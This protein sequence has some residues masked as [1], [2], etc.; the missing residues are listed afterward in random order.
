MVAV[1]QFECQHLYL[2]GRLSV[3]IKMNEHLMTGVVSFNVTFMFIFHPNIPHLTLSEDAI[4]YK[5]TLQSCKV[6]ISTAY[7]NHS[8][9]VFLTFPFCLPLYRS[10]SLCFALPPSF[11]QPLLSFSSITKDG[12]VLS[13]HVQIMLLMTHF[14]FSHCCF[15]L[16][17]YISHHWLH[18]V[19]L[20]T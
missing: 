10:I 17:G 9:T 8:L 12:L 4:V 19:P 3:L 13:H 5:P 7:A 16:V 1:F 20:T 11:L 14:L 15:L 6:T 2:S 18:E